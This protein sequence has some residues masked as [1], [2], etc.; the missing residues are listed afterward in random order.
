MLLGQKPGLCDGAEGL[1]R[2]PGV[3]VLAADN[4]GSQAIQ[5]RLRIRLTGEALGVFVAALVDP[6][7]APP[8]DLAVHARPL[9]ADFAVGALRLPVPPVVDARPLVPDNCVHGHT[10]YRSDPFADVR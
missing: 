5:E 3:D 2:L 9:G 4:V 8:G 10:S 6:P 7:H 1:A